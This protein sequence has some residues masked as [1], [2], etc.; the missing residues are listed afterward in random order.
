M[1][2]LLLPFSAGFRAGVALRSA[3]YKHG[4]LK[5]RRLARPVVSVG[6][7]TVGGTGKTPLVACVAGML[8]SRGWKPSILTRGYRRRSSEDMLVVA[9]GGAPPR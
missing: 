4:W 8:L 7:I 3:A 6:N 1:N 9:P 2:P 5:V